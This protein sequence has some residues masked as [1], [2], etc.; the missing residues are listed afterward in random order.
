MTD[1]IHDLI[2]Q[3]D[4]MPTPE[5][6]VQILNIMDKMNDK[7]NAVES[8]AGAAAARSSMLANGIQPD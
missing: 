3:C 5:T 8:T 2:Q 7:I 6:L 1:E 4:T